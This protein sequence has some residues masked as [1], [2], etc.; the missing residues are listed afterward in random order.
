LADCAPAGIET[1][2]DGSGP[3]VPPTQARQ[4]WFEVGL[5]LLIACGGSLVN[6]LYLLKNG[7][8]PVLGASTL[9][10][11]YSLVHEISA[12][13]LLSYVLSRRGLQF[14]DIGLR[15]STRDVGAGVLLT[16]AAFGAYVLGLFF[17]ELF[18]HWVYGSWAIVHGGKDFFAHPAVAFVPFILFNP[19]FEELIVRAY[20]MSEIFDLTRSSHLAVVG[21]V[22]VQTSYHL[23]YGWAGAISL[24]FQFLVFS[25]YYSRS[26][27]AL[28]IIVAHG[29]FD[30]YGSSRLW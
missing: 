15:W 26:R 27:Q 10:W 5:V 3:E 2:Y 29:L 1:A 16:A 11:S 17:V 7:P 24:S 8:S 28:P 21:S 22:L 6:A 4:R 12:L 25:L 18:H 13:L 23:Y 19:F 20:L 14:K 30:I 9:R